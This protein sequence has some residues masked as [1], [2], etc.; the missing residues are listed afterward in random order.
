MEQEIWKPISGHENRYLISNLGRVKRLPIIVSNNRKRGPFKSH[1]KER[2]LTLSTNVGGYYTAFIFDKHRPVHRLVAQA[3][4]PN[5]ENKPT[6]NHKDCN[7]KNNNVDNLEW[8]TVME[9]VHHA[10]DNG[11]VPIRRG[12][13]NNKAKLTEVDVLA[14]RSSGMN[15]RELGELYGVHK[16]NIGYIRRKITW[17]HI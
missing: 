9:N 14:I 5:P 11:L 3:F 6:V 15:N 13:E 7:K 4:I 12:E 1:K 17:K 2:I 16:S 10:H 8:A